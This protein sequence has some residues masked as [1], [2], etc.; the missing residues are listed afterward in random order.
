VRAVGLA[1]CLGLL[2]LPVSAL[3]VQRSVTAH[4]RADGGAAQPLVKGTRVPPSA[5]VETAGAGALDLRLERFGDLELGADAAFVPLQMPTPGNDEVTHLRLLRG[6]LRVRWQTD[7]SPRAWPMVVDVDGVRLSLA[8]GEYFV[9]T[10]PRE[11]LFC[12]AAGRAAVAI[13]GRRAPAE[14]AGRSCHRLR[15]GQP[16]TALAY[17]PRA[18]QRAPDTRRLAAALRGDPSMPAAAPPPKVSRS[19]AFAAAMQ[20]AISGRPQQPLRVA[21]GPAPA[22]SSWTV[23]AGS[24]PQQSLAERFLSE[25]A[26]KG[27]GGAA[28]VPADV[29]GKTWY[30][31]CFVGVASRDEAQGLIDRLKRD[32]QVLSAWMQ[33][34]R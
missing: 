29:G 16:P 17:A 30:R 20:A 5:V 28:I 21:R 10:T 2:S 23:F 24:F 4:V 31:V 15:I 22:P 34:L 27:F 13:R 8:Q 25:L 6:Y 14:L 1:L 18:L 12:I 11:T 3:T 26:D 32:A 19:A 9:E 33:G 7:L